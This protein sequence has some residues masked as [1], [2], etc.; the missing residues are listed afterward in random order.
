M[1]IDNIAYEELSPPEE[2]PAE[3]KKKELKKRRELLKLVNF[4][5]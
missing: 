4:S 3:K 1:D 2:E 5:K